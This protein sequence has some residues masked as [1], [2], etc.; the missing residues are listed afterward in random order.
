MDKNGNGNK[1][2]KRKGFLTFWFGLMLV[3]NF[4]AGILYLF[5]NTMQLVYPNAT[6]WIFY[7]YTLLA[8]VNVIFVIF[9][10]KWKKWAFYGFCATAGI[11]F[12]LNLTIR[13]SIAS[14]VAGLLGPLILYLIMKP[15]WKYFE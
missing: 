8:F 14:S 15:Q 6:P 7:I 4:I 2:V 12:I 3:S 9:L 10:F 11:A 5:S 13:L 1:T